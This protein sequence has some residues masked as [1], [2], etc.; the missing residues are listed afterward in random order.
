MDLALCHEPIARDSTTYIQTSA[1][2]FMRKLGA[3]DA[4]N[5]ATSDPLPRR[6]ST[7]HRAANR[8]FNPLHLINYD[9]EARNCTTHDSRRTQL[10]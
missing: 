3:P 8:Y 7:Q 10:Q 1:H 5:A 9:L 6:V 4:A 2:E